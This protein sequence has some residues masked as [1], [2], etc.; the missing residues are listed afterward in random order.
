[1]NP[2]SKNMLRLRRQ[3]GMT[4]AELAEKMAVTRQTISNWE[5]GKS[6]PDIES[7]KALAEA[8]SVPIERLI[9]DRPPGAERKKSLFAAAAEVFPP[10]VW[11]RRLG[12]FVLLFG[13]VCGIAAGSGA[14]QT[15]DGGVGWG[16]SW[17]EALPVWYTALIRGTILLGISHILVILRDRG[18]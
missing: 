8:L 4:Q 2:V 18:P 11:C 13:L 12:L 1:M 3:K 15:S 6:Q 10:E 9:Y 14:V 5:S 16:F 17:F 7:L